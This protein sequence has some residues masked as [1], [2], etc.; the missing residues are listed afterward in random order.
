MAI[1]QS[2]SSQKIPWNLWIQWRHKY[3]KHKFPSQKEEIIR[4]DHVPHLGMPYLLPK[5]PC[6]Q[7]WLCQPTLKCYP[8]HVSFIRTCSLPRACVSHCLPR[9]PP[10]P[11]IDLNKQSKISVADNGT[12][13]LVIL[14][15]LFPFAL[16]SHFVLINNADEKN[17]AKCLL[18]NDLSKCWTA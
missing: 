9:L 6:I 17:G 15:K 12:Q 1:A 3:S 4:F 14:S 10:L 5:W 13:M 8:T 16:C 7:L 18:S 2:S 11:P